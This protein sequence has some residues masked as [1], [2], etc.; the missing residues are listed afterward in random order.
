M[1]IFIT[2]AT[3]GMGLEVAKIYLSRGH[4]VATCSFQEEREISAS[5]PRELIYYKAD[6]TD[7]EALAHAIND[8]AQKNNGLD[9]CFANAG[10]SMDKST[11]PDFDRGRRVIDINI[12]GVLNTFEP[13]LAIMK[14]Q[15]SGHIVGM[16][17]ISGF[18]GMPGMGIYGASK[19]AVIN[20]METFSADLIHHNIHSTCVS[21]GFV[22][23]PLTENNPHKM[24]FM[25]TKE[26]AAARIVKGIENKKNLVVFSFPM[27]MV[28]IVLK[29]LPRPV[30]AILMKHDL[31]GLRGEH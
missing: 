22:L 18:T 8:F 31:I 13:A 14:K 6:V 30:Y 24:P 12:H 1:N 10:I 16:G 28:S 17:S 26:D 7:K 4:K 5:I 2:G 3:T 11:F 20:L 9:I 25:I 23:T 29:Y 21:P 19:S 15:K 27:K